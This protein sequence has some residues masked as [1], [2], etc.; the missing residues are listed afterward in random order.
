MSVVSM[1]ELL[2][3]I[4]R[5]DPGIEIVGEARNGVEAALLAEFVQL[6]YRRATA[7]SNSTGQSS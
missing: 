7:L 6:L 1:R 5:S 3:A 4:L 2:V